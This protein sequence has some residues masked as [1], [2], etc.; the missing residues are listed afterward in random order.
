MRM[1]VVG[2]VLCL[3]VSATAQETIRGDSRSTDFGGTESAVEQAGEKTGDAT[4]AD[5][6]AD[7]MEA[8]GLRPF[9]DSDV[10]MQSLMK[11]LQFG[12]GCARGPQDECPG[13]RER[14]AGAGDRLA[15]YLVEQFERSDPARF[16]GR[17]LYLEYMAFTQS[18]TAFDFL[19]ARLKSR[20]DL[21]DSEI[22]QTV[23]AL[24]YM[25]DERVIDEVMP[26]FGEAETL[27]LRGHVIRAVVRTMEL[28]GSQ[29]AHAVAWLQTLAEQPDYQYYVSKKLK[30][31]GVQE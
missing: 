6:Y 24:G 16:A 4:A 5:A 2:C 22:G 26:V 17:D 1:T 21:S 19:I 7:A 14:L 8:A 23:R 30:S 15:R 9:D 25:G 18:D 13:A 11:S 29:P 28:S 20:A 27:D 10:E 31:L 12:G 3:A